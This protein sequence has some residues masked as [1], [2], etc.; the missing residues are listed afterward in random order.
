MSPIQLPNRLENLPRALALCKISKPLD[1]AGKSCGKSD[2][3]RF[4]FKLGFGWISYSEI[5][6]C[7]LAILSQNW[8]E[9]DPMSL[10]SSEFRPSSG[11]L[12]NIT[13]RVFALSYH[14]MWQFTTIWSVREVFIFRP[15]TTR[16]IHY[17]VFNIFLS[18]YFM[19]RPFVNTEKKKITSETSNP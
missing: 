15:K 4:K 2:F 13:R 10:A 12:K 9:I 8:P 7:I 14:Q 6:S 16:Y 17:L 18:R 19:P 3:A 11:T 5:T 1:K